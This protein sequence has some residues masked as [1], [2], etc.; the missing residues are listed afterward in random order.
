VREAKLLG[1]AFRK[2]WLPG[3]KARNLR[4]RNDVRLIRSVVEVDGEQRDD[5]QTSIQ[6]PKSTARS[7]TKPVPVVRLPWLA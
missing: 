5:Y 7:A 6:R 4:S 3:L 1:L 2:C